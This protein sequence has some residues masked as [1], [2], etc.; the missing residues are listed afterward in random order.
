MY[1]TTDG[2]VVSIS[3]MV[4]TKPLELY[5]SCVYLTLGICMHG[6]GH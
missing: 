2:E 5:L 4:C 6:V 3:V 1:A